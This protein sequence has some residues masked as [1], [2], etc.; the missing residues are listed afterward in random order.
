MKGRGSIAW[1]GQGPRLGSLRRRRDG[2]GLL[3]GLGLLVV[4][5][6]VAWLWVAVIGEDLSRGTHLGARH[7][8]EDLP[9]KP[10]PVAVIAPRSP[11]GPAAPGLPA[12][13][14]EPAVDPVAQSLVAA[15]RDH[16]ARKVTPVWHHVDDPRD[17][18]GSHLDLI[19][20]GLGDLLPL[21]NAL[22]RH[23]YREPQRYGLTSRPPATT[24]ERRR[25]LTAENLAIF[26][27]AFGTRVE[28][29]ALEPGDVVL[30]ERKRGNRLLAAVVSDVLDD[31]GG[32]QLVVLDPAYPAA[33]E[34]RLQAGYVVRHRFRLSAQQVEKARQALDLGTTARP[35][36]A[37]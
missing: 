35:G 23:R 21:R 11:G 28:G 34:V 22:V 1:H 5:A 29:E 20:R 7:K 15:A 4:V 16:L 13:R 25:A 12:R 26:L 36:L 33:R 32:P 10:Q 18:H 2:L 37:L 17:S 6:G 30:V 3:R 19:D 31:A 24:D 8:D 9:Q 14:V 27:E